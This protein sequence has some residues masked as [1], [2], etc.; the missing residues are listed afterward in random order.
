MHICQLNAL[1]QVVCLII[2]SG[3]RIGEDTGG[4]AREVFRRL[5]KD[6]RVVAVIELQG[7]LEFNEG[8]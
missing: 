6:V 5:T 7:L 3:W 8:A 2:N 4:R 1:S